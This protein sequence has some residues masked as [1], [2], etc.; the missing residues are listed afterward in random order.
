MKDYVKPVVLVNEE[1]A[2]G[3]YAASGADGNGCFRYLKYTGGDLSTADGYYEYNVEFVHAAEAHMNCTHKIVIYFSSSPKEAS[4][5]TN[6]TDAVIGNNSVT[7]TWA[8][9][10]ANGGGE[11]ADIGIKV[12]WEEGV[13]GVPTGGYG[14][15]E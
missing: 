13:Y 3:V 10:Q 4:C 11:H 12:L 14:W 8:Q 2:E 5:I 6:C 1:T 9:A 15:V 7:V